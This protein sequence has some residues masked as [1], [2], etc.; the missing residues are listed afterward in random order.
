MANYFT[1]QALIDSVKR[2]ANIPDSQ[3]MIT[4]DEILDFANE[5]MLLNLIPLVVSKH[6]DYY[7]TEEQ[8]SV[9]DNQKNYQIPYRALGTALRELAFYKDGRYHE[10]HRVPLD[11]I[12]DSSYRNVPFSNHRFYIKDES[13]IIDTLSTSVGFDTLSF[14]YNMRPNALVSSDRV[15][16]VTAI[17]TTTGII[18]VAAVPEAFEGAT[19]LD[20]IK[21]NAPHRILDYD[22]VP[23]LI[24]NANSQITFATTD[25]PPVLQIGD[26]ICLAQ[27]TDLVNAPTELHPM[28]AQMVAARVLESIGDTQGLQNVNDKLARME[29]NTNHLITNRVSGSPIK[30]SSRRNLN[31]NRRRGK[32]Y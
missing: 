13:V 3:A 9:I 25:I 12:T 21:L 31:K 20:F 24:D 6:E 19:K 14:F 8:V 29:Q 26:H 1:S 16:V 11:E 17:D 28:L 30:C 15:A 32:F 23:T 22:I 2:R 18:T 10:L 27:E 4:D 7:L 5:E